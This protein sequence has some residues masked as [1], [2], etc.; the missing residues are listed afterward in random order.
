MKAKILDLI[1]FEKVDTLL[2]GF[3]RTTGFVTAILDLEGNVLSKSGWRT[4]CTEFHRIHPETSK[5]CTSSDTILAGKMAEGEK[6]HFYKCLNGLVDVAVPIVIK[7]EHI[8]NLFT[9]QFFFSE[10]DRSF[11]VQQANKY[12]F[13]SEQYLKALAEVPVFS[14]EQV[15]PVLDFLL[16][17]TEMIAEMTMRRIQETQLND[18]LKESEETYRNI[19]EFSPIAAAFWDKEAKIIFWNKTAEEIFGWSKDEVIGRKFTEFFVPESAR[20]YVEENVDL[21]IKNISRETTLNENL[22]K[23]GTAILCEWTNTIIHD[24]DGNPATIISLAND[25]TE[26][27][28]AEKLL[29]QSEERL[30]KIFNSS[31]SAI[32]VSR[33]SDGTFI[34]LNEAACKIY[35]FKRDEVIGRTSLELG[36]IDPRERMRLVTSLQSEGF[37]RNQ[38]VIIHSRN[39][40][41]RMVL[42]SMDIMNIDGEQ[43]M[44]TSMV[45][46]TDRKRTELELARA[47]ESEKAALIEANKAKEQLSQTMERISDGFG[48]LDRHWN[49]TFVNERLA[50]NVNKK[51][52]DLLGRNIWEVFPEAIGTSV[53]KAYLRSMEE[54]AVIDL[55]HFYPPF[56]KWFQHRFYP[57]PDGISVFSKDI[58]ENKLAEEK[59]RENNSLLRIAAEKA[60]LGGWNVDLKENR[61]YW[62]D[63]VATIH[64]MPAGYAPLVED[65]INFY[66]P[67][68]RDRIIKVFTDCAQ[69][70]IPY[71][72]EM[73]IITSTGK[74]VWVRTIGE[75]VR[76]ENGKIVKVEGAFQDIS[77]RK[78]VEE[79]SR[80]KDRQFRKLSANVPDL[81][82]QLTRKPD[83]SYCVPVA[84]EGIKNIFGCSPEDVVDDFTPIS[85]VI[86][87]D[88]AEKVMA[89]IENSAKHLTH[90]TC[91]FRVQIPG[92]PVQ[93]IL[94]RSTPE[95]LPDGSITWYGFYADIT[96]RKAFEDAL[97]ESE[98]KF[99][100][101][102]EEGPF[103]MALVNGNFKFI[104]VNRKFCEITGYTESELKKFTF[105]DITY[106]EDKDIGF[107]SIL[108]LI[109]GEIPVYKS[110]KRYVRRDGTLI[111]AAITVTAN[112]DKNGNFLY[113]VA[114]VEDITDRKLAEMK[115]LESE[116]ELKQALQFSNESRLTLLRV[117][118]D[119]QN[120][121]Q[122]LN[123][124]NEELE[125]RVQERTEELQIS[126]QNYRNIF[127]TSPVSIRKEDWSEVISSIQKLRNDG[128]T[129]FKEY[130]DSNPKFVEKVLSEIRIIDVNETT[131]S[132]F[133]ADSKEQV[134]QSLNIVFS[135]PDVLPGFVGELIALADGLQFYETDMALRTTKKELIQVLLRM[136][137][138]EPGSSSG[139]VLVTLIDI[140]QRKKTEAELEHSKLRLL[141]AN[142][143]L[144][145]FT[146]SVSHDLKAPLRGIDGFSKLLSDLHAN[147]LN[148][149]AKHFISTIRKSTQLMSQLIDDLLL[150]S[151]LERSQLRSERV[152]IKSIVNAILKINEDEIVSGGFSVVTDIPDTAIIADS[153][154]IQM[155]L[156]NLIDNAIKFTKKVVEP[157][158]EIKQDE[159]EHCWIISVKDNGPGFDMKYSQRIFEIFQRLH[160]VEDYP[161]TGI[162]LAMVSKAMQRLNGRAWAESAPGKGATFYL[163]IPKPL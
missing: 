123:K 107:E 84:S 161:G 3:N 31:P 36:I 143:E 134:K 96:Q 32:V 29:F 58:T 146:Y 28:R 142:K 98:G 12:R 14:E 59:I 55:E 75:A 127:E 80:E 25:I 147:E 104:M 91:E 34:D 20:K 8:A 72:E 117:L 148:D 112:F 155:A 30:S 88:D 57:S 153:N 126:E 67:E 11:F 125:Q 103:G 18:A 46:I 70:G 132:M 92:G 120:T 1:D 136:V 73:E 51:R 152:M 42:Y 144:E 93:W 160:R 149:E 48:S 150:Y 2:E 87:P 122:K 9:G 69:N 37:L 115:I 77:E 85:K 163:E 43:C 141:E 52:E 121:Q 131:L 114:I 105:S 40:G 66:A 111:W 64:E 135:T 97:S 118:E 124:L 79:K 23:D 113:N 39:Q 108:K 63:V 71:D 116:A 74:R 119:Q 16:N 19:F 35:G 10:P 129:D 156:R 22:R 145:T 82:F 53:Q 78:F 62:S 5:K 4:I 33:I 106:P 139:I 68:W 89:E 140:T 133:E 38:E 45:D 41:D 17:M 65:G 50:K 162:G 95:K 26:R 60:K 13:N 128:I 159:S 49:Y 56:G 101:I 94:S 86:H 102:Y 27:K 130:F 138:P 44:L 100:K 151:R 158:I 24:K 109:K 81:I 157:T 21:L 154:G 7:G 76:D 47:F 54:Q 6:Y 110:E 83:G 15:K 90:F 137:F 99:R 61:S